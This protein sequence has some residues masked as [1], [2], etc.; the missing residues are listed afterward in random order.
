M[1]RRVRI[2]LLLFVLFFVALSSWLTK[3]RS[4]DWTRTQWLVIY[5]INGDGRPATQHYIDGLTVASYRPI[6]EFLNR[7]A[8][9]YR[10]NVAHPVDIQLAP[11]V[12]A[13]PP[14]PPPGMPAA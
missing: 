14:P 1:F 9:H 6:E 3:I 4:T 7:E 5:P 13:V 10:L 12:N 11:Q 8:E 2:A